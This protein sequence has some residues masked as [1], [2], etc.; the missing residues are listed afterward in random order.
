M[1]ASYTIIDTLE[2]IKNEYELM[3]SDMEDIIQ[4]LKSEGLTLAVL[5][6]CHR[7]YSAKCEI[8]KEFAE[9]I[10][11]EISFLLYEANDNKDTK[12][13]IKGE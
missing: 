9:V 3:V 10:L 1:K 5:N 4:T 8:C 2:M 11:D 6:N 7:D 12:T 13:L